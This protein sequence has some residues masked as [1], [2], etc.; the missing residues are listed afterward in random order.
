MPCSDS[1]FRNPLI[2]LSGSEKLYKDNANRVQNEINGF[3]SFA[4]VPLILYKDNANRMQNEINGFISFVEVI[5][6]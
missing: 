1:M 4:E 2:S 5:Q 6:R 3:I